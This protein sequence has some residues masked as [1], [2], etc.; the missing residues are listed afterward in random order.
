VES[1]TIGILL[2]NVDSAGLGV[3]IA[4]VEERPAVVGSERGIDAKGM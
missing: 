1:S 3:G 2:L 4:D